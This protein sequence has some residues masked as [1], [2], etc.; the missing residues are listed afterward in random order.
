MKTRRPLVVTKRD[1]T[2]ERFDPAKLRNVLSAAMQRRGYDPRLADP[3][4]RAVAL[5]LREW[6]GDRP[7]TTQYI[8]QCVCAVLEQTDLEEV[9]ADLRW[10]RRQRAL[11]RRAIEVVAD[12]GGS[13]APWRKSA[14]ARALQDKYGL[15]QS[16]SR[17]LA[18]RI[19]QQVLGL[20]FRR[21]RKSLIAELVRCEVAAWGL[22]D[23]PQ[24]VP[25]PAADPA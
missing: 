15:R 9:A 14:V 3:L 2:L 25:P 19:E 5:H 18:G 21:V 11:R 13:S 22:S 10:H 6:A 8:H 23:E 12:P 1:G 4:M 17:V 7:P 16:V 20:G 24:L